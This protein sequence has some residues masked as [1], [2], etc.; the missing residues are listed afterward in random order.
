MRTIPALIAAFL[1]TAMVSGVLLLVGA[2]ALLNAN[3]VPVSDSKQASNSSTGIIQMDQH[4]V[5]QLESRIQQYQQREKQYQTD[6]NIAAQR[7]NQS[8][9][10]IR[11]YQQLIVALQQ[12]G[13]IQVSPDGQVMIPQQRINDDNFFGGSN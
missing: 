12:A 11:S 4:Q 7:I 8:N 3:T 13:V 2:N 5:Q 10:Q 9:Q 6:L 1:I